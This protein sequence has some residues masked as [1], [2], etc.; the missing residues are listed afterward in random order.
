MATTIVMDLACFLGSMAIYLF[1]FFVLHVVVLRLIRTKRLATTLNYLIAVS[2][3]MTFFI[4]LF[5]LKGGY[6]SLS[7]YVVGTTGTIIASI[8]I[9]GFYGFSG[10]ICADRSPSAHMA[11]V[12]LEDEEDALSREEMMERY[13]YEKVFD[14]RI[15]DFLNSK[16][17]R[18]SDNKYRLT[19]KGRRLSLYYLFLIKL[20]RL[21]KNYQ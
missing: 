13:G 20:L 14:R 18:R 11:L 21:D 6:S 19:P 10:P 3:I 1:L 16:I 17:V 5:F 4:T 8:F 2:G 9:L 12:L 15:N 7:T